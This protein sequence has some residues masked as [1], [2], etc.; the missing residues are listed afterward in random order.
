MAHCGIFQ[1][2]NLKRWCAAVSY[3]KNYGSY[4][5]PLASK[6]ACVRVRV[7]FVP[8][9]LQA[10]VVNISIDLTCIIQNNLELFFPKQH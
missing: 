4:R 10:R 2:W 9:K 3:S 1:V 6:G 8:V 5:F 7:K